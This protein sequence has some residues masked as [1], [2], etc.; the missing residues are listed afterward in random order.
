[1]LNK[2]KA[3]QDAHGLT[4]GICLPLCEWSWETALSTPIPDIV[5][6][7]CGLKFFQTFEHESAI[8]RLRF[9]YRGHARTPEERTRMRYMKWLMIIFSACTLIPAA[10]FALALDSWAGMSLNRP[11]LAGFIAFGVLIAIIV[12]F[13]SRRKVTLLLPL[14][15]ILVMLVLPFINSSPV[16]PAVRAVNQIRPGMTQAEARLVIEQNFPQGGRFKPPTLVTE[17]TNRLA[18]VIDPDDG[19][20]NAAL[21]VVR[22]S[23]G[24]TVS[25]EFQAD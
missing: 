19:A 24:K 23:D 7:S 3:K 20:Y 14:A 11:F 16:K 2:P 15:Y 10:L 6:N 17:E 5:L 1:M 9:G 4:T 13:V 21:I 18:Y 25:A 22:F 8:A 12:G